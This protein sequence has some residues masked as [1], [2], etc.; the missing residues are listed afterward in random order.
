[1]PK[2]TNVRN[3]GS[4]TTLDIESMARETRPGPTLV[5]VFFFG[6]EDEPA[7]FAFSADFVFFFFEEPSM[8]KYARDI[9]RNYILSFVQ[10]SIWTSI[11]CER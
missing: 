2:V 11:L 3:L 6:L 10:F 4:S 5:Y 9:V 7:D 8:M 1:M